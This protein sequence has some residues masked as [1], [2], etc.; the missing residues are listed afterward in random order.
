MKCSGCGKNP[1]GTEVC[2]F[3][4]FSLTEGGSWQHKPV[5]RLAVASLVIALAS[6][7]VLVLQPLLLIIGLPAALIL[8]IAGLLTIYKSKGKLRGYG[9]ATAGIVVSCLL[10]VVVFITV[11]K[12]V[13]I[14]VCGE[15]LH[16]LSWV[17]RAYSNDNDGKY[18][19]PNKWCDLL[20]EGGYVTKEE[21]FKCP[22]N[23]KARCSYAINPNTDINSPG[24]MVLLFETKG[25]W[26][27]FG[28][29]ELVST[30]NHNGEGF[31]V[32]YNDFYIRFEKTSG[33]EQLRWR[34]EENK[35]ND[36]AE[37]N[38]VR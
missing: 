10:V 9:F 4:G 12:I 27:Q 16:A 22:G 11:S 26:N 33:V 35:E 28:G 29:P 23:K 21:Q 37:A 6:L 36:K 1:D 17:I 8:G 24:D 7:G 2:D 32:L 3:C 14:W 34:V 19:T 13:R 38:D 31:N 5:S 20:L 30:D 18:P 25:G 15:N